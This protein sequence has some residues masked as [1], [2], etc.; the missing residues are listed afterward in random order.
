MACRR[1]WFER[2][3]A[4]VGYAWLALGS[5]LALMSYGNRLF[6]RLPSI[7]YLP[8]QSFVCTSLCAGILVLFREK[9]NRQSAFTKTLSANKTT[10]LRF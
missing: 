1:R 9:F 8:W 3:P 2:I 10:L 6:W 4:S 7:I 5:V